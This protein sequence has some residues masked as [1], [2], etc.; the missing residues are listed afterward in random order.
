MWA[1]KWP[2]SVCLWLFSIGQWIIYTNIKIIQRLWCRPVNWKSNISNH[3]LLSCTS[4]IQF[5]PEYIAESRILM[6]GYEYVDTIKLSA[7]HANFRSCLQ[8]VTHA[9][10]FVV[11]LFVIDVW[12]QLPVFIATYRQASLLI[13]RN[14]TLYCRA[15]ESLVRL[16]CSTVA[17]YDV[18]FYH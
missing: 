10:L 13:K 3:Y 18:F 8:T 2:I 12:I 16:S 6:R 11:V 9:K 14:Q 17:L 1:I 4:T 15:C 5:F 7:V